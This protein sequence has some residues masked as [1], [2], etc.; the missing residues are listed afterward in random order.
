MGGLVFHGGSV[1]AH[2]VEPEGTHEPHRLVTNEAAHVLPPHQR[3]MFPELF[4]VEIVEH[5]A[6]TD[7]LRGH[8]VEY[9]RRIREIGPQPLGE[10]PIDAGVF[11]FVADGEGED[12][13]L[14]EINKALHRSSPAE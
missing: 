13:L 2:L 11:L 10:V 4:A 9:L 14:G 12:F 8:L 3:Q 1:F 7:F 6:V 5:P